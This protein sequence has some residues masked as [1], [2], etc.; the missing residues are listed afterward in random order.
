MFNGS[1]E[2]RKA[3]VQASEVVGY[4]AKYS[5]LGICYLGVAIGVSIKLGNKTVK[6][7][8]AHI[9]NLK[10]KEGEIEC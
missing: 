1:I 4:L 6:I 2:D 5:F 7:I 9:P 8:K 3:I 10:G